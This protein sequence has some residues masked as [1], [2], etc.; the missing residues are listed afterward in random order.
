MYTKIKRIELGQ[1]NRNIHRY[2]IAEHDI[3]EMTVVCFSENNPNSVRASRVGSKDVDKG[4]ALQN[5]KAG[6]PIKV[7]AKGRISNYFITTE[8]IYIVD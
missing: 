1:F 4:V 8:E 5:A 6:E 2:P 3:E 7:L